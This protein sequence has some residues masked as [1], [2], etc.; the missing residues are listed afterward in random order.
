M[1]A[2]CARC[3]DDRWVCEAH[4]ERPWG[5]SPARLSVRRGRVA[6]AIERTDMPGRLVTSAAGFVAIGR[7]SVIEACRDSLRIPATS[8]VDF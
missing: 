1:A 5:A 4:N 3:D 8:S 2:S 7:K 6:A